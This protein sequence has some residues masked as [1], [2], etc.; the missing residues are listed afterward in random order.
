M[1][2]IQKLESSFILKGSVS[3]SLSGGSLRPVRYGRGSTSEPAC[4]AAVTQTAGDVLVAGEDLL[5]CASF[6]PPSSAPH[7]ACSS[8]GLWVTV[9]QCNMGSSQAC[10]SIFHSVYGCFQQHSCKYQQNKNVKDK[11]PDRNNLAVRKNIWEAWP[12]SCF[13]VWSKCLHYFQPFYFSPRYSLD[14][15]S[16]CFSLPLAEGPGAPSRAVLYW[17]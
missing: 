16:M 2:D 11:L 4:I 6:R 17:Q 13:P 5:Q 14:S 12:D 1:S 8:S 15:H 7:Q 9:L 3:T 10:H